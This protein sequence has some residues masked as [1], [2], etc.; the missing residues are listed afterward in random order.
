VTSTV[1]TI[2]DGSLRAAHETTRPLN[3]YLHTFVVHLPLDAADEDEALQLA[4]LV[5]R[6]AMGISRA[7]IEA[8]A[9]SVEISCDARS[10]WCGREFLAGARCGLRAGHP[11][12]HRAFVTSGDDETSASH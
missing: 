3:D 1:W 8:A 10:I 6:A 2:A 9:I 5:A 12:V 7:R 11:G 4:E